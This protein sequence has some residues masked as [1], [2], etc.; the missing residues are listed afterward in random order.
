MVVWTNEWNVG[1]LASFCDRGSS[2]ASHGAY[3]RISSEAPLNE[4]EAAAVEERQ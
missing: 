2:K 1:T 4:S 3:F